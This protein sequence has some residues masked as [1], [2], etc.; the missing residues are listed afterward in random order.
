[1]A[2]EITTK[3]SAFGA[4]SGQGTSS[5]AGG[6][7]GR[8]WIRACKITLGSGGE[9]IDVSELRCEFVVRQ[10]DVQQPDWAYV[11]IYNLSEQTSRWGMLKENDTVTIEAGYESRIGMIYKGKIMQK[12][13]G[14][15]GNGTDKY[16]DVLATGN[17]KAYGYARANKTLAAGYTQKDVIEQV[18]LPEFKKF[19]IE[20]GHIDD[21][22]MKKSPRAGTF[23]GLARDI[24]R[25]VGMTTNT[26]WRFHNEKFQMIKNDGYLPNQTKVV[27]SETGM[28]G[29]PEQTINGIIVK[30]LLDPEMQPGILIKVDEGSVQESLLSPG[31]DQ[32]AIQ[33]GIMPKISDDG[34]YRIYRVDHDGDTKG[35]QWYTTVTCLARNDQSVGGGQT[36][37][38]TPKD[39]WHPEHRAVTE[40]D[41]TATGNKSA[42]GV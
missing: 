16:F 25:D 29:Q 14:K 23:F 2:L 35:Q 18:V 9:G 32:G 26:S 41:D 15:L 33:R 8:Q 20:V 36:R 10:K 38:N 3:P 30:M 11:R 31:I 19:G 4:G 7:S 27:N 37:T 13:K 17:Q 12:R 24:A 21:L 1:M 40:E 39:D 22:G 5:G 42:G 6:G 28:I 34:T